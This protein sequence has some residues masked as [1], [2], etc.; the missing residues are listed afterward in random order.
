MWRL[1]KT[2]DTSRVDFHNHDN[3]PT[4]QPGNPPPKSSTGLPR[5]TTVAQAR[6]HPG[7]TMFHGALWWRKR[8]SALI[9]SATTGAR[10]THGSLSEPRG[11]IYPYGEIG[12]RVDMSNTAGDYYRITFRDLPIDMLHWLVMILRSARHH[13]EFGR[14]SRTSELLDKLDCAIRT[15]P[16]AVQVAIDVDGK[17]VGRRRGE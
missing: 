2:G 3:R 6:H 16:K 17:C 15:Q 4:P 10:E 7:D 9:A 11:P 1:R 5:E 8:R 13:E 14:D 12:M